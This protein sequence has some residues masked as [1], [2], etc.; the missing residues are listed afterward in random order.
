MRDLLH[1]DH[2]P[3]TPARLA[4][5]GLRFAFTSDGQTATEM[6]RGVR[7][8]MA[9]GLKPDDA[10][11]ALTLSAAELYGLGERTGSLEKGK[12]ANL[13]VTRNDLLAERPDI[14]FI[15]VDGVKYAPVEPPAQ[16]SGRPTNAPSEEEEEEDPE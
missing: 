3:S 14:Q 11:R 13:V 5:A 12:I 9:R 2:A 16:R 4:A 6:L 8:A 15:V 7:K 10:L 1:R